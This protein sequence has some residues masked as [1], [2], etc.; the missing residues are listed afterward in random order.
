MT[1]YDWPARAGDP[2]PDDRRGLD[3]WN[4]ARGLPGRGDLLPDP[5]PEPPAVES[6]VDEPEDASVVV[7]T[8][9]FLEEASSSLLHAAAPSPRTVC[10]MCSSSVAPV[11]MMCTPR[12]R[13]SSR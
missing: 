9:S 3:A 7:V 5:V 6:V 13:R 11:P 4:G 2:R 8:S 12:R 1:A 10:P